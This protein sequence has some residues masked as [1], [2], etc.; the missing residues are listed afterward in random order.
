MIHKIKTVVMITAV[1]ITSATA[2]LMIRTFD[3]EQDRECVIFDS[4]TVRDDSL[5]CSVYWGDDMR[6]GD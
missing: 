6:Q 4:I 1:M 2:S 3:V 5:L